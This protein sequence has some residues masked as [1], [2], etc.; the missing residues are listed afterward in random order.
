MGRSVPL[1]RKT[2]LVTFSWPNILPVNIAY[3]IHK[4]LLMTTNFKQMNQ[5]GNALK[6]ESAVDIISRTRYVGT[7]SSI[8]RPNSSAMLL[9]LSQR[10]HEPGS[11]PPS[12]I[13]TGARRAQ[14]RGWLIDLVDCFDCLGWPRNPF[15]Q[16]REPA[17]HLPFLEALYT[18]T[19]QP[20]LGDIVSNCQMLLQT[21]IPSN[22]CQS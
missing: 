5:G 3:P 18:L 22:Q 21:P 1:A 8:A 15:L 19:Q 13:V 4:M 14:G 16:T 17:S 6:S 12:R 11:P 9:M 10:T 20:G 7:S 2:T